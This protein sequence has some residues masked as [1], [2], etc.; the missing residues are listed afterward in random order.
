MAA[1]CDCVGGQIVC[2]CVFYG[3]CLKLDSLLFFINIKEVTFNFLCS[4]V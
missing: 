4:P 3:M 1:E 2:D